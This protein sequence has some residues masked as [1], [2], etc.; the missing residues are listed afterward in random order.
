MLIEFVNFVLYGVLKAL[1]PEH[2]SVGM[3]DGDKVQGAEPNDLL[4]N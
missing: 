4:T 3:E 1:G 2:R